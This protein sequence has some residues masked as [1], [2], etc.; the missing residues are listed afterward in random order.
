MLK[1]TI[2]MI[3]TM[4]T[5]IKYNMICAQIYP[6]AKYF[7]L[8]KR[9]K[10]KTIKLAPT[11]RLTSI[12]TCGINSV[13]ITTGKLKIPARKLKVIKNK[14]HKSILLLLE[15]KKSEIIKNASTITMIT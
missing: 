6:L 13:K 11:D 1:I 10:K 3:S 8:K 9:L 14:T 7:S 4:A 12:W 15:A 2:N 5:P